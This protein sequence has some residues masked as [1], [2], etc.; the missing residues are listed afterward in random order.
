MTTIFDFCNNT[1]YL[2]ERKDNSSIL[3]YGF[4]DKY[5]EFEISDFGTIKGNSI[6]TNMNK[7]QT[8]FNTN[9]I[10]DL[11]ITYITEKKQ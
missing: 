11:Y 3:F 9:S 6:N 1:V 2:K 8:Y 4:D 7:A 5:L 10:K